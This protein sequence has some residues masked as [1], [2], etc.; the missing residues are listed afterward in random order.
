M[1]TPGKPHEADRYA[2]EQIAR[3][4]R[5]EAFLQLGPHERYTA[6]GME[7]YAEA[8]EGAA[9]LNAKSKYGRRAVIYA[10]NPEGRAFPVDD[11]L[12][13]MAGLI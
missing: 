12:A 2:A 5:F 1:P 10:I 13:R 6:S 7:T 4:V 8:L 9:Q 3:A 11:D